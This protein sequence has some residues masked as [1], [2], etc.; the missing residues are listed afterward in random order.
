MLYGVF[1]PLLLQRAAQLGFRD[2]NPAALGFD[3]S[4]AITRIR[5]QSGSRGSQG[6][7]RDGRGQGVARFTEIPKWH[8]EPGKN[9][10]ELG[11]LT[12]S[13]GDNC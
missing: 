8:R 12:K 4:L 7:H 13:N 9:V 5:V 2:F 10:F 6:W 11:L 3:Q 1:C